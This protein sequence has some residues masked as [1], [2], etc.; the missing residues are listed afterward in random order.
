MKAKL[1]MTK[2][3][4][5]ML[6]IIVMMMKKMIWKQFI[7][8]WIFRCLKWAGDWKLL[9]INRLAESYGD[10]SGPYGFFFHSFLRPV[11]LLP[12]LLLH[13]SWFFYAPFRPIWLLWLHASEVPA[14]AFCSC[15]SIKA[16]RLFK[17]FEIESNQHWKGIEEEEIKYSKQSNEMN[18]L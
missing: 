15:P 1:K 14:E 10:Y 6:M 9:M 12:P 16:K 13:T 2:T 3:E 8:N 17:A 4:V 5:Y 11:D 18:T 7:A